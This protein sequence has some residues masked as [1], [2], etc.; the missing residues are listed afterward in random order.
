MH[1][2]FAVVFGRVLEG[3]DIVDKIQN[4]KVDRS[5]KPAQPITI[6]DCGKL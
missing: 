4:M 5:A 6:A 1:C 3:Y 2:V